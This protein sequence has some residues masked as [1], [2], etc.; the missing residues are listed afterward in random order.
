MYIEVSW[1]VYN[2][3]LDLDNEVFFLVTIKTGSNV[4]SIFDGITEVYS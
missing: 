2:I 3:A 4:R 1:S